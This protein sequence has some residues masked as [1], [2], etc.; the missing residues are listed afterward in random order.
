[1]PDPLDLT[2]THKSLYAPSAKEPV[3]VTVPA[4]NYLMLDGKGNP[5]GNPQYQAVVEALYQFSYGL[6][7]A[8]KKAGG[9]DYKVMPLEGLWWA[10][11]MAQFSMERKDEWLWTMLILQPDPVT[12]EWVEKIRGQLL[13]KKEASPLVSQVGF[14]TYHEGA[15]VQIMHLGPYADEGPNIARMHAY[16]HEM[17]YRLRSKHHE[18]YLSDPRRAAPEKM[19]TVLRQ[20]VEK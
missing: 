19:R 6:K 4:F 13:A 12:T 5:N 10:A 15:C 17:G 14:E 3:M 9:V 1:M 20:P 2:K 8:I 18:I 11:D 7:F 16:A